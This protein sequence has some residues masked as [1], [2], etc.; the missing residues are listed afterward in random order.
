MFAKTVKAGCEVGGSRAR[1]H[2]SMVAWKGEK[3]TIQ[4]TENRGNQAAQ[5]GEAMTFK[6]RSFPLSL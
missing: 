5:R 1:S 3:P 6:N 2:L 4:K